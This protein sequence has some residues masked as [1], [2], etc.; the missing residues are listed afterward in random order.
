MVMRLCKDDC[1]S[2]E[3][4]GRRAIYR[5][6]QMSPGKAILAPVNEGGDL[7]ERDRDA[8]DP[9]KYLIR[10]ASSLQRL[11]ARQV[12][13]DPLGQVWERRWP[14]EGQIRRNC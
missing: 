14:N 13:V 4:D 10:S 11:K 12:V 9:F 3:V 5:L 8:S 6:A 1:V 2:I 7:R